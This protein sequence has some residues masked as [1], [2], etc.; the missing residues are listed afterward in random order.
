MKQSIKTVIGLY[1]SDRHQQIKELLELLV[2]KSFI[3]G[4]YVAGA[5]SFNRVDKY[6]DL[7]IHCVVE[8]GSGQRLW[9]T[10]DKHFYKEN[11]LLYKTNQ[12]HYPWFGNMRTYYTLH[13]DI[14]YFDVGYVEDVQAADFYYQW[15]GIVVKDNKI[16][17]RKWVR[18]SE[19]NEDIKVHN[20]LRFQ[21]D[22]LFSTSIKIK[23]DVARKLYWNAT[24][25][26]TQLRRSFV[27][28]YSYEN[29]YREKFPFVGRPERDIEKI[30]REKDLSLLRETIPDG[31]F[32]SIVKAKNKI[33]EYSKKLRCLK[34]NNHLGFA[35]SK[36]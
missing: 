8:K 28:L 30:W 19:K 34:E 22:Q 5:I 27:F 2:S 23:K 13:N 32:E 17:L 26:L 11:D 6:S 20:L 29:Y 14:F 15:K 1:P 9:S 35:L 7:D 12:R 36:V 4:I 18:T 3:K 16:Q 21:L 31:S 25:N 10:L 24:E 33:I